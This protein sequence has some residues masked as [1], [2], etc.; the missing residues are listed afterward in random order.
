MNGWKSACII[1]RLL[2][3]TLLVR[4][5]RVQ[6]ILYGNEIVIHWHIL[7]VQPTKR[8]IIHFTAHTLLFF[9]NISLISGCIC[10]IEKKKCSNEFIGEKITYSVYLNTYLVRKKTECHTVQITFCNWTLFDNRQMS[11]SV[12]VG[13][14]THYSQRIWL[15][16]QSICKPLVLFQP[17]Q[18]GMNGFEGQPATMSELNGFRTLNFWVELLKPYEFTR[19]CRSTCKQMLN[20]KLF[21]KLNMLKTSK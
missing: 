18:E 16:L 19:L 2:H 4:L 21:S 3:S 5:L 14:I 12:G 13:T 8:L 17:P 10:Q 6:E 7:C 20:D 11:I 15:T 9:F 1:C